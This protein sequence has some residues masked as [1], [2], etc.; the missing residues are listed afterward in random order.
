MSPSI[1][2]FLDWRNIFH[3]HVG[4]SRITLGNDMIQWGDDTLDCLV[5]F[6]SIKVSQV[7]SNYTMKE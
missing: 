1:V 4:E 2:V 5:Y 3:V 6:T 7:E